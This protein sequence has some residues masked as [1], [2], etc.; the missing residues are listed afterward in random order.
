[1]SLQM[2]DADTGRRVRIVK[3][4]MQRVWCQG[5]CIVFVELDQCAD[6]M[7]GLSVFRR[8]SIRLE[9]MF[10][11]VSGNERGKKEGKN[12]QGQCKQNQGECV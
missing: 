8:E 6:Q 12:R 7:T 1:M 9:F 10:S 5:G 4:G 11:G 3:S 2:M